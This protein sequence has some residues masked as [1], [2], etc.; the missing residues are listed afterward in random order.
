MPLAKKMLNEG[1]KHSQSRWD[2]CGEDKGRA[3]TRTL[4]AQHGPLRGPDQAVRFGTGQQ[5]GR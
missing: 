3:P 1:L 2:G 5:D 4:S